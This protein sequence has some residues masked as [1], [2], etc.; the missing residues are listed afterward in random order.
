MIE[1][2]WFSYAG[3]K[4]TKEQVKWAIAHI[5]LLREGQWPPSHKESGYTGNPIGKKQRSTQA[6]FINAAS[7]AAELDLRIQRA[8]VDG[9]MLEFLYSLDPDD[10][11]FVI[12]HMAQCLNLER[13][14]V[15][16]RIRNAL[17]YVSGNKRKTDK[18][19]RYISKSKEYLKVK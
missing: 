5:Q 11:R 6:P 15:S 10:E 1:K 18:Y 19:S 4:F 9:L 17:Y 8:G 14:E 2:E 7:I 13:R 16:Q 12:E 3:F